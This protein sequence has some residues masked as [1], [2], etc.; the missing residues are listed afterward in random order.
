LKMH[1]H[2]LNIIVQYQL[3]M[4]NWRGIMPVW[5]HWHFQWCGYRCTAEWNMYSKDQQP[6]ESPYRGS[7]V[8]LPSPD[9]PTLFS[10]S[11]QN[12]LFC[13]VSHI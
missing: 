11:R 7:N 1:S 13:A 4:K 6:L 5:C 2:E 8:S 12:T 10:P 9:C 3:G